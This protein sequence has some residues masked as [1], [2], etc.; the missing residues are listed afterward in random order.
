MPIYGER[1]GIWADALDP[2]VRFRFDLAFNRRVS[3]IPSL[4]NV[5]GSV[6]AYEQVSGVGAVGIEA[7]DAW[8]QTGHVGEADFDQGYKATY[9]HKEYPM[10]IRIQRKLID[11]ANF[12][13]VFRLIE[14]VGDS[15]ALKREVDAASIFNNA[16]TDTAPYAG[17][18]S[19]GLC[20]SAHPNSPQKTSATQENEGTYSL[21]V[22]NIATVREAMM[23]FT[24]DNGNKMGVT[25]N[26]LLVPP[27]L[28]DEARVY[29]NSVNKA[30]TANN[31]LNPRAGEQWQI[32]V[33][34]YLT[35][36]TYWFMLDT[37]LM[38][39]SLDW[40]NR[41]PI[42]INPIVEDKTMSAGWRAYMRYSLGWSD[43]RWVYGNNF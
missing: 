18:D 2:I 30:G 37:A 26:A 4:F 21:S 41:V 38:M 3:L 12:P 34:H 40:F 24:D 33:W 16:F 8:E 28:E 25:P 22:D 5:Q 1:N 42:T 23:A 14:R 11:D 19:V 17:P 29:L 13:Q 7:W 43:W 35:D 9:T 36:S 27:A 32:Y 15:A 10:D 31:D 6:R 39:Q 20:S